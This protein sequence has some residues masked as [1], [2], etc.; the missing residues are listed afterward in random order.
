MKNLS[1]SCWQQSNQVIQ[2][3]HSVFLWCTC[4]KLIVRRNEGVG[5]KRVGKRRVT[6]IQKSEEKAGKQGIGQE[7]KQEVT[8]LQYSSIA[9]TVRESTVVLPAIVKSFSKVR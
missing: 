5:G 2:Q 1:V 9:C 3:R 4:V 8:Y 7:E 6:R